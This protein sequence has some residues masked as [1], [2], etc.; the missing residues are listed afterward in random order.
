[1][2]KELEVSLRRRSGSEPPDPSSIRSL[3]LSYQAKMEEKEKRY[4]AD[5]TKLE[6]LDEDP[7]EGRVS[8]YMAWWD[9]LEWEGEER[10]RMFV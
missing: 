3:N 7:I 10:K 1:M 2:A 8:A 6:M 9:V 4:S 5:S